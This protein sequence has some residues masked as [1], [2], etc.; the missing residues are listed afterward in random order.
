MERGGKEGGPNQPGDTPTDSG[1]TAE[2]PYSSAQ[3]VFILFGTAWRRADECDSLQ[4]VGQSNP[5]VALPSV[6]VGP[7]ARVTHPSSP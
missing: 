2:F 7:A 1:A 6:S 5:R 3:V 4:L